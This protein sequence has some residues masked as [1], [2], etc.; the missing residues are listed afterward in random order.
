VNKAVGQPPDSLLGSLRAALI[1]H[2]HESDLTVTKAAKICGYN[3]RRL[4]REL[5]D[6]GTTLSKEIAKLRAERAKTS[7]ADTNQR[8]AEIALAVGFSDPTVFS[9]AFKN[10]TEQSPQEYRRTHR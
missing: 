5:H 1:P 8:V 9:R 2:L 6:E 4:S 7:L 3:K 10:W